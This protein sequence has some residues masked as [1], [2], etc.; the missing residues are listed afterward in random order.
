MCGVLFD[1]E[2]GDDAKIQFDTPVLE[3]SVTLGTLRHGPVTVD[4]GG[5]DMKVVFE[6]AP[7]GVGREA[8]M[9]FTD[10]DAP[11]GATTPYWIR[12]VQTDGAKAWVSPFYVT[13]T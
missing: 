8:R 9:S 10:T 2:G 6:M 1:V 7:E 11:K 3:R 4:A 12:V 13:V 5:V